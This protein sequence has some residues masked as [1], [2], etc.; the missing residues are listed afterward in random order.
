MKREKGEEKRTKTPEI[1]KKK[2]G[3]KIYANTGEKNQRNR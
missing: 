2:N 3:K 1:R